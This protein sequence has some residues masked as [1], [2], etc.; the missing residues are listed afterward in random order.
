MSSLHITQLLKWT[1]PEDAI[2]I[3]ASIEANEDKAFMFFAVN[4]ASTTSEGFSRGDNAFFELDSLGGTNR[5][6]TNKLVSSLRVT[7]NVPTAGLI[8]LRSLQQPNGFDCGVFEIA[9]IEMCSQ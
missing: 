7:L 8:E 9:N 5:S 1:D 6:A 3:L 2:S 4:N